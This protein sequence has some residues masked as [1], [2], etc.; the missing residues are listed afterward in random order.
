MAIA[1]RA[2]AFPAV[3]FRLVTDYSHIHK[4]AHSH[5]CFHIHAEMI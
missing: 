1:V 2:G 5:E 3:A 4:I